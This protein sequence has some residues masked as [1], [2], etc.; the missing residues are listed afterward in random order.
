MQKC[1]PAEM[2]LAL[3]FSQGAKIAMEIGVRSAHPQRPLQQQPIAASSAGASSAAASSAAASSAVTSPAVDR[4]AADK[5][6][7][8]LFSEVLRGAGRVGFASAHTAEQ[9]DAQA[10]RPLEERIAQTWNDWYQTTQSGRYATPKMTASL[11]EG[12]GNI[13]Q[14]AYEAGGY[15]APHAFLNSLSPA[16]LATVQHVHLLAEPIQVDS[17]SEE[18]ALNLLLPAAAQ[19]DLNR[20]GLTHSGAGAILKFP[21]STTP[22]AV[23]AAW[24][25]AT[26]DLPFGER[27]TYVLQMKL[28]V[29]LANMELD[30]QGHFVRQRQP[31]DADFVNPLAAAGYSFEQA[32]SAWMDHLNYFKNQLDPARY[33]KDMQFWQ[34]FQ[35]ALRDNSAQSTLR[36]A[37]A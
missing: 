28:P 4:R 14:R 32:A 29:L 21:D 37:T 7:Q 20:D 33:A 3:P 8:S 31:G 18:G 30:Q 19:V 10:S 11:G 36:R 6:L 25:Q 26:Q 17:L 2:S 27:M 22:P 16:E 1:L 35:S 15:V 34:T 13:L 9:G 5:S 12:F 24:E 23:V